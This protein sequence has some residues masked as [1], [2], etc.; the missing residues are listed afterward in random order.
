M[1]NAYVKGLADVKKRCQ[2]WENALQQILSK[3]E[4]QKIYQAHIFINA[5]EACTVLGQYITAIA[6]IRM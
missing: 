2:N 6:H 5:D 4:V 1:K 3:T